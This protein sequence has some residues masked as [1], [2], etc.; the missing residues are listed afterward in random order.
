MKKL[1]AL[2]FVL[3]FMASAIGCT[4]KSDS[5]IPQ[6]S[7]GGDQANVYEY[8]IQEDGVQYLVLP[9][10]RSKIRI[11]DEYVKYLDKIDI[12]LLGAAEATISDQMDSS[13]TDLFYLQED[14]SGNLC[15]CAEMIV[16]INPPQ[17]RTDERGNIYDKG[18]GIDHRHVFFS[19]RI[20]A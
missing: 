13:Y 2:F 11:R 3:V 20:T 4:M 10:S 18:C 12:E 5:G 7:D 9:I 1:I 16:D 15:L 8:L 6:K 19:E 17:T 14:Y